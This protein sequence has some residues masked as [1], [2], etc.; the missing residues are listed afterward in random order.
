MSMF[1]TPAIWSRYTALN[2]GSNLSLPAAYSGKESNPSNRG[3]VQVNESLVDYLE[4]NTQ[5]TTYL[6]AVPTSM[7]GA[8]YVLATGRPVLYIGGFKGADEVVNADD[9]SQLVEDGE[10]RYIY[11]GSQGMGNNSEIASWVT[12]ACVPVQGFDTTTRNSGAPDGT[13]AAANVSTGSNRQSI[14]L[15]DCEIKNENK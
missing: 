11:W 1:I 8:D 4:A 5:D 13:T 14:T 3:N 9:L 2:P 12:S 6:M 10:L 15:Y 7:Q